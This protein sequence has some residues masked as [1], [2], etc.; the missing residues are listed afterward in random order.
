MSKQP[1]IIIKILKALKPFI[2]ESS[3]AIAKK[4]ILYYLSVKH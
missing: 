3:S 2:V 4:T 1:L